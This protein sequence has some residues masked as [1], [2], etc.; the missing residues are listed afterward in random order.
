[1]YF[2]LMMFIKAQHW[3]NTQHSLQFYGLREPPVWYSLKC[4]QTIFFS[5]MNICG[6]A[7]LMYFGLCIQEEFS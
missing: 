5:H 3:A 4:L 6:A 7:G 2:G 1:M